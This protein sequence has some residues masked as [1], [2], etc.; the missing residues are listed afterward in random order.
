GTGV[1]WGSQTLLIKTNMLAIS[2]GYYDA[3]CRLDPDGRVFLG[4]WNTGGSYSDV[5]NVVAITP[6]P[7]VLLRDDGTVVVR[8]TNSP[9][10]SNIVAVASTANGANPILLALQR[11]GT[12]V[13]W[14]DSLPIPAGLSNVVAVATG[15]IRMAL[16]RDG[17]IVVWGN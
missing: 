4:T 11:D 13:S 9:P 5:S 15:F 6:Y 16:R 17:T 10:F 2:L 12:V 14:N 3:Y 7:S 8:G 1:R